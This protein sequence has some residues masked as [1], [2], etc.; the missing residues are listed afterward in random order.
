MSARIGIHQRRTKCHL[1]GFKRTVE[2]VGDGIIAHIDRRVTETLDQELRIPR[3]PG[4]K[5]IG[6][7]ASPLVQPIQSRLETVSGFNAIC[8]HLFQE[9]GRMSTKRGSHNQ[10]NPLT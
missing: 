6:S 10:R 9:P 5:S 1:P 8:F 2:E 7:R 4:T 3:Q